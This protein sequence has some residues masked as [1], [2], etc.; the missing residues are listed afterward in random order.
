MR[1]GHIGRNTTSP[2]VYPMED[3]LTFAIG[4]VKLWI[5]MTAPLVKVRG[6]YLATYNSSF[7]TGRRA[8]AL[9]WA[10]SRLAM[11]FA[12]RPPSFTP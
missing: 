4:D 10:S 2:V 9:C 3:L 8:S 1:A 5:K 12:L 7:N 6:F 11:P